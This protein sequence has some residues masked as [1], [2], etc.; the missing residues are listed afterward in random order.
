MY[1]H[2]EFNRSALKGVC[3]N[4]GKPLKLGSHIKLRSWEAYVMVDDQFTSFPTYVTTSN[5]VVLRQM[6]YEEIEGNPQNLGALGP[7]LLGMGA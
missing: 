4:T 2:T 5:L 7:R 1:H 3:I 6:V